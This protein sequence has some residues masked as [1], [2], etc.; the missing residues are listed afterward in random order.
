MGKMRSVLLG[1]AHIIINKC[2]FNFYFCPNMD[3]FPRNNIRFFRTIGDNL[4]GALATF[5]RNMSVIHQEISAPNMQGETNFKVYR[6][7]NTH[8]HSKIPIMI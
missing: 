8:S 1:M 2:N 3:I 5:A 7:Q 4:P 6:T